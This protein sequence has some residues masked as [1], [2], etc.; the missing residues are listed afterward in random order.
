MSPTTTTT[1]KPSDF[2][3]VQLTADGA[4]VAP[5]R[6]TNGHFVYKFKPGATQRVLTSEWSKIISKEKWQGK[7]LFELVPDAPAAAAVPAPAATPKPAA[8]Q[9]TVEK[10][11]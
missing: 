8:A 5:V 6:I 7:P 3:E 9:S 4:K 11:S 10:G 1:Q 2:V